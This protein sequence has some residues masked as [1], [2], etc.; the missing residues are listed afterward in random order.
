MCWDEDVV[1]WEDKDSKRHK[2]CIDTELQCI[3]LQLMILVSY[4]R[5]LCLTRFLLFSSR[6]FIVLN[7]TIKSLIHFKLNIC[8]QYTV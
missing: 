8:V 7:C 5:N 3:L 2:S 6:S 1:V 4:L